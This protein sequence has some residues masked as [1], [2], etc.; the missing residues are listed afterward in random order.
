MLSHSCAVAWVPLSKLTYR[1]FST[2]SRLSPGPP[3]HHP[4][5]AY[6]RACTASEAPTAPVS[7]PSSAISHSGSQHIP[8]HLSSLRPR[9]RLQ[10]F[11]LACER[12]GAEGSRGRARASSFHVQTIAWGKPWGNDL[13]PSRA[14]SGLL[15]T[16]LVRFSTCLGAVPLGH[17]VLKRFSSAQGGG[18]DTSGARGSE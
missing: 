10:P 13:F 4:Q 9:T 1:A 12:P 18:S 8:A 11:E 15:P 14:V 2:L 5:P 7:A 17:N 6:E 3:W 16:S